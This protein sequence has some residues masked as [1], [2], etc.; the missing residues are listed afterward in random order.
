MAVKTDERFQ[1]HLAAADP[2]VRAALS[3]VERWAAAEALTYRE[4]PTSR[5]FVLSSGRGVAWFFAPTGRSSRVLELDLKWL[6]AR[7]PAAARRAVEALE[8]LQLSPTADYPRI[9]YRT[10]LRRWDGLSSGVLTP[11][12]EA[13]RRLD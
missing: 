4:T 9:P 2:D 11:Y 10:I 13:Q 8:A 12:L 6:R 5:V 3:V 1:D 7:D